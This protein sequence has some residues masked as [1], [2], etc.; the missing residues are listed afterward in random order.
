MIGTRFIFVLLLSNDSIMFVW[1]A[2]SGFGTVFCIQIH[3]SSPLFTVSTLVV[4]E[5]SQLL[6]LNYLQRLV[7]VTVGRHG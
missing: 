6:G 4:L 7:T 2:A 3:F 5:S 1:E